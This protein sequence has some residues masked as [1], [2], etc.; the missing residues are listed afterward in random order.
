MYVK[1]IV[2]STAKTK[3]AIQ[4]SQNWDLVILQNIKTKLQNLRFDGFKREIDLYSTS[5][6]FLFFCSKKFKRAL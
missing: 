2:I 3:N 4:Y 1:P 5:I 6:F